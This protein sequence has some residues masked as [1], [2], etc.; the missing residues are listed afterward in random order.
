[1]KLKRITNKAILS[2]LIL[3]KTSSKK[4]EHAKKFLSDNHS[5]IEWATDGI[6]TVIKQNEKVSVSKRRTSKNED[7]KSTVRGLTIAFFRLMREE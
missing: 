5:K 2:A 1:M 3:N 6:Y 4:I 7:T